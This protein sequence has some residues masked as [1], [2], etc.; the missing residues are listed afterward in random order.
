[1]TNDEKSEDKKKLVEVYAEISKIYDLPDFNKLT[2]DFDVDKCDSE[3][4]YLI[5][6]FRRIIGEKI[7]AYL[8]FFETLINPASPPVYIYS[9]LK[10]LDTKNRD[11]I[12]EIYKVLARSQVRLMQLDTVYDEKKEAEFLTKFFDD[13]QVF[14]KDIYQIMQSLDA[15]FDNLSNAGKRSYLG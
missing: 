15:S 12:K 13:W 10:T 9:F 8:H 6:S 2:E 4:E 14:K 7:N 5:R 11:S 1:M 3:D